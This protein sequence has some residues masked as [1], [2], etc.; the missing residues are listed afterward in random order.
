[1]VLRQVEWRFGPPTPWVSRTIEAMP[2]NLV[3][4]LGR[5][6]FDLKNTAELRAWL[7]ANSR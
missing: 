4:E 6:L 7:R 2:A 5:R 3:E 1:M